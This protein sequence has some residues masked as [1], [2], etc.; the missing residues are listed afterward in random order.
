LAPCY[1]GMETLLAGEILARARREHLTQLPD[2][3]G[4]RVLVLG[5][6]PGRYLETLL[7]R[8]AAAKIVVVENSARMIEAAGRAIGSVGRRRVEFLHRDATRWEPEPGAF[9]VVATHFFLDCFPAAVLAER[10]PRWSSGLAVGGVWLVSDFQV[11]EQGWRGL[12]A[13]WIH[14]LMYAFFRVATGLEAQRWTDPDPFL[15]GAGLRLEARTRLNHGL[16]RS[17]LWRKVGSPES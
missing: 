3:E 2:R 13:R 12:R 16:V 4:L 10:V 15:E 1:R 14:A 17:D 9:D 7:A 6:G 11:P 8:N 5:E